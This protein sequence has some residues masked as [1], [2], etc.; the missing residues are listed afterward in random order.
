VV[1]VGRDYSDVSPVDGVI[2]AI[3]GQDLTVAVDVLPRDERGPEAAADR[4]E[5]LPADAAAAGGPAGEAA[6]AA[7]ASA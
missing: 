2:R 5:D 3:G 4:P 7:S 6:D 1:A